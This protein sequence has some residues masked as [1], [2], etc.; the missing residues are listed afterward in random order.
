[1]SI[2]FLFWLLMILWLIFGVEWGGFSDSRYRVV[3][4]GLLLWVLLALLG[5]A[6][7]GSPIK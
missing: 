4:G 6:Q 1:M 2:S 3:G 5:Y 7:F